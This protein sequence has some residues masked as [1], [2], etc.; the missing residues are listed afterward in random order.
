MEENTDYYSLSNTNSRSVAFFGNATYSYKQRYILNGT[1]RYEGS[2]AMGR[3]RSARWTPTWNVAGSWNVDQE[4][5]FQSWMPAISHLKL[6]ASYSLTATPPPTSYTSSTNVYKAYSP[7][8]LLTGD[9]E[10]G[11]QLSQLE[12]DELTYE[13]SMSLTSVSRLVS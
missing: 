3:S 9:K 13:K 8:R 11:I 6:K 2:N 10:T 4:K 1:Y 5:F 12:N 7:W